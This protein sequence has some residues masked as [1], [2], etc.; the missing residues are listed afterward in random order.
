MSVIAVDVD[1]SIEA[2]GY[3]AGEFAVDV[4][5][6]HEIAGGGLEVRKVGFGGEAELEEFCGCVSTVG[7][8]SEF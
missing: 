4:K 6:A 3:F 5:L 7:S 8:R 1:E 2:D